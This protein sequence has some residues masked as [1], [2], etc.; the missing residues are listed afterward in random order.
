MQK[1]TPR[2]FEK[3]LQGVSGLS[4]TERDRFRHVLHGY[5]DR[6]ATS[7]G[8]SPMGYLSEREKNEAIEYMKKEHRSLYL[9]PEKIDKLGEALGK[10]F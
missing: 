3:T 10:H 8:G 2:Q 7:L 1:I 4:S 9:P 6:D 5:F